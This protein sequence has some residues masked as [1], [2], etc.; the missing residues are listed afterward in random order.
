V[1]RIIRKS[2]FQ[3]RMVAAIVLI[4][5]ASVGLG[6][7][8][9]YFFGHAAL[10]NTI[11][12]TYQEL[13]EVTANNVDKEINNHLRVSLT[14][15]LARDILRVV[16]ESNDAYAGSTDQE[17]TQHLSAIES[18]WSNDQGVGAYLHALLTNE[19]TAYLRS[20][21]NHVNRT[22][23]THLQ[24]LVTDAHGAVVAATKKPRH[25]DYSKTQWWRQVM[26]TGQPFL[27]DIVLSEAD[28]SY[29]FPIAYPVFKGPDEVS[30]VLYTVYDAPQFFKLVTDVKFGRTDHTMLVSSDGE[31]IFCPILPIKSHT[32]QK[33]L[34]SLALREVAGWVSSE[35][36]V[37]YPGKQAISGFAPVSI[38]LKADSGNFGG[39]HW[40]ILTSQ[41]PKE[42]FAPILDLLKWVAIAGVVGAFLVALMGFLAAR[43]VVRPINLLRDGVERIS[44]GDLNHRI[45]IRTGDEIEQLGQS[46][47]QMS[48]KLSASYAGLEA[49]VTERTRALEAKNRELYT[50]YTIVSTLNET[51][52]AEGFKQ[53]LSKILMNLHVDAI[54]LTIDS[55]SGESLTYSAPEGALSDRACRRAM[56]T[57]EQHVH[58]RNLALLIE[59]LGQNPRFNLLE[60]DLGYKGVAIMPVSLHDRNI[61]MLHILSRRSR[62]YTATERAL[63]TSILNQLGTCIEHLKLNR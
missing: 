4:G 44:S 55:P 25:Y 20:F 30:G 36:D 29:I 32:L 49:K 8:S 48:E 31:I 61:G 46:F 37:H 18:R 58:D 3:Q 39:K 62:T 47:N 24:I 13:A 43:R 17:I 10:K 19:G 9:V 51:H 21:D 57:L 53:A 52:S 27:G 54:A 34:Q 42:A 38:T 41:D 26:Q 59:D 7:A 45:D 33:G 60:K 28:D 22:H 16:N 6:L 5:V 12:S 50:L 40:Y 1:N 23:L 63:I 2:G 14:L 56:S 35:Q 11:G 15:T